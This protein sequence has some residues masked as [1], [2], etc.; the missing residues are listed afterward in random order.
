MDLELADRVQGMNL[1]NRNDTGDIKMVDLHRNSSHRMTDPLGSRQHEVKDTG[2]HKGLG[3]YL[4][5]TR[6]RHPPTAKESFER[7]KNANAASWHEVC[8]C[9]DIGFADLDRSVSLN[10]SLASCL[11][12]TDPL[13]QS[14]G[15]GTPK[16]LAESMRKTW[17]HSPSSER[18]IEDVFNLPGVLDKIIA[19]KGSVVSD[20]ILRT[21]RRVI[22]GKKKPRCRQRKDTLKAAGHHPELDKVYEKVMDSQVWMQKLWGL[23]D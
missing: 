10:V 7:A 20:E 17:T 16:V 15:L 8:K 14:W 4:E 2:I 1:D 12:I 5:G 9:V 21:G 22:A 13:R 6:A 11:P 3:C 18:I 23:G 19:A